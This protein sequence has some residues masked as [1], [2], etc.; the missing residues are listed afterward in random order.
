VAG[1]D[2]LLTLA[3]FDHVDSAT[4]EVA[5]SEFGRLAEEV[6]APT[7]R[8]G[9]L[10][11]STLDASSGTVHVPEEFHKAY[12]QFVDGGWAALAFPLE[13]GGGGFPALV[14]MAIQEMFASA[15]VALSLNPALTQS[16]IELLLHWGSESQKRR[17]LPRLLAG[18]WS[19]T[20][21]LSEPGA[22][23]DLGEIR[24]EAEADGDRW[25]LTGTKVFISWGEHDLTANIVHMV[26]ART[27][28]APTGT[29]GLSI[30]LVPRLL[31][32]VAGE[33]STKNAITCTRVEEKLGL[34][35]SPTC[36]LEFDR[37]EAELVGPLHGG[38]RAM[39][40]MMNAAR[41]SIGLQGPSIGESAYQQ[42]LDYARTRR[43]GAAPAAGPARALI[44]DHPDVRRM[45]LTMRVLTLASRML[46]YSATGY[47]DVARH[48]TDEAARAAAQEYVD[49]LTPVAK[50]WSTDAGVAVA[51][52]GIQ[53]LGGVGYIEETG[54][55]QR[56]GQPDR[57]HL[58]G[59]KRHP[60]RRPGDP[61]AAPKP[62]CA[63]PSAH[64]LDG[65]HGGVAPQ[66]PGP[67][68]E[69][70][71][72]GRGT[73][74]PEN[75]DRV[76]PGANRNS[77]GRRPRRCL[78]IPR[79]ARY[80]RGRMAHGSPRRAGARER[81][82]YPIGSGE[83]LLRHRDPGPGTRTD[84]PD[85]RRGAALGGRATSRLSRVRVE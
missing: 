33:P 29:R 3:P 68:R 76:D 81:V 5:L 51:S 14:G 32:D 83:Q 84:P 40:T 52:L 72:P 80:E 27:P 48:G 79:V 43:Q 28:G 41:L 55:A 22:G 56:S 70:G 38:M 75:G 15:N 31:L 64:R 6:L 30:F 53:V 71:D 67:L 63:D 59:D 85:H 65:R 66:R 45:L 17:F 8:P 54:M 82:G 50:A 23:S 35:A 57:T 24:T 12:G 47:R 77:A 19:G 20:M 26:L 9:D 39:F 2:D 18:A 69:P 13:W 61:K 16:A 62:R 74:H 36:V 4:V 11:G 58:R 37:A 7:D 21:V 60:S 42:A 34:H 25:R 10:T 78:C 46:V 49:L 1:L 44:V 73:R